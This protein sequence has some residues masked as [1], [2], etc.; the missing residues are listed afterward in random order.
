MI[1]LL[2]ILILSSYSLEVTVIDEM[3]SECSSTNYSLLSALGQP[4]VIGIA[5]STNYKSR[6]GFL[7]YFAGL[8]Y[9]PEGIE[10]ENFHTTLCGIRPN[11]SKAPVCI[12][13]S[14]S[15]K[16]FV[17]L[18]IYD[19]TGRVVRV[20]QNGLIKAGEYRLWWDCRDLNNYKVPAGVYFYSLIINNTPVSIK[21][22]ILLK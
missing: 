8:G 13:Y 16:S 22:F 5:A 17:S 6:F 11:P 3:G 19:I 15:E 14:I 12:E 9:I 10:I 1:T 20:L 2:L 18:R 4:S 21:K 7:G